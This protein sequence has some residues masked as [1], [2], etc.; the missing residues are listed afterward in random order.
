MVTKFTKLRTTDLGIWQS[1]NDT[2]TDA[3]SQCSRISF[4]KRY[5][6]ACRLRAAKLKGSPVIDSTV[7][8]PLAV[9]EHNIANPISYL[10]TKRLLAFTF[11]PCRYHLLRMQHLQQKNPSILQFDQP[12]HLRN[13]PPLA[14]PHP[15]RTGPFS[16]LGPQSPIPLRFDP[17]AGER[18][19]HYSSK[20]Y[21]CELSPKASSR[22]H[23][24]RDEGTLVEFT[25][26]SGV[27]RAAGATD[28]RG[29][30]Q[31]YAMRGSRSSSS[32]GG[33]RELPGWEY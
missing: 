20:P 28:A 6:T 9:H 26:S 27:Q 19:C 12:H 3:P 15:L 1:W 2:N 18:T 29:N 10:R 4:C 7:Q 33:R 32:G 24:P 17:P 21:L 22:T 13:P 8:K 25:I 5:S 31:A 23:I 30:H 11:F 14:S 16:S